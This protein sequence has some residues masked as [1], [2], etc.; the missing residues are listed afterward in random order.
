MV[1]KEILRFVYNAYKVGNPI[2]KAQI[3]AALDIEIEFDFDDYD[4][5][6]WHP[7]YNFIK[8]VMDVKGIDLIKPIYE[9]YSL[10]KE[11]KEAIKKLGNTPIEEPDLV[12]ALDDGDEDDKT[13]AIV[14]A[15]GINVDELSL[16]HF[17]LLLREI[18]THVMEH[19][20]E[21]GDIKPIDS[22]L[23][24]GVIDKNLADKIRKAADGNTSDTEIL[25]TLFDVV[26]EKYNFD[27][28]VSYWEK[29]HI[30]MYLM[31]EFSGATSLMGL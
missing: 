29:E 6:K 22:T 23:R 4:M 9:K 26:R 14:D 28:D 7:Q 10:P 19:V 13:K 30:A 12:K 21:N 27:K 1:N 25:D 18:K 8:K 16:Q 20:D 24:I 17:T 2:I 3:E 31:R 5:T 15:T 11:I